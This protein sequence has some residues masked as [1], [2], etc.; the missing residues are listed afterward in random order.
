M[1]LPEWRTANTA[2]Y[3]RAMAAGILVAADP[4][5]FIGGYTTVPDNPDF[6]ASAGLGT[7]CDDDGTHGCGTGNSVAVAHLGLATVG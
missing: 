2:A 6:R 4:I 1:R 3:D 7:R 5:C